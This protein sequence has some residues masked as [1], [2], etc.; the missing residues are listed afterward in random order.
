MQNTQWD[1]VLTD[2][3]DWNGKTWVNNII[4]QVLKESTPQ[5]DFL[6]TL[7]PGMTGTEAWIFRD[8]FP[9]LKI[10]GAEPQTDRYEFLKDKFP[11]DLLNCAVAAHEGKTEGWMGHKAGKS[12]FW[13][14]ADENNSKHYIKQEIL[15]NTVDNILKNV[16]GHGFLWMD[17]EGAEFEALRGALQSMLTRKVLFINA[18]I[19]FSLKKDKTYPDPTFIIHLLHSLGYIAIG[20]PSC[21]ISEHNGYSFCSSVEVS[22]HTDILFAQ[23]GTESGIPLHYLTV[24]PG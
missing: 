16:E 9:N 20:S 6:L 12:D 22:S 10:I 14:N 11:G 2:T 15:C 17:I 4:N 5:I 1:R 21:E 13:L 3:Q 8:H 24:V 18:E 7:G 23:L 19:D